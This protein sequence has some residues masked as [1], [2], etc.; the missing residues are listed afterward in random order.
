MSFSHPLGILREVPP[1]LAPQRVL[2]PTTAFFLPLV[3]A[4]GTLPAA[5]PLSLPLGTLSPFS[6]VFFSDGF[7]FRA[8]F[9]PR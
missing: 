2:H 3:G 8:I 9:L 4:G 1:S 5:R 7:G 6:P